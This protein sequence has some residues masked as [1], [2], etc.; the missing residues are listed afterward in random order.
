MSQSENSKIALETSKRRLIANGV[1]ANL[2]SPLHA[3]PE[4]FE[5]SQDID[6]IERG[7][8]I[9][10]WTHMVWTARSKCLPRARDHKDAAETIA[11]KEKVSTRVIRP[12]AKRAVLSF[13]P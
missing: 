4:T 7:F 9:E 3:A 2:F 10:S 5:S 8:R 11:R 1:P 13:E 12:G 6:D